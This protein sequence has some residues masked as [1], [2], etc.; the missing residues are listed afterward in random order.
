MLRE[1][2]EPDAEGKLREHDAEG[3]YRKFDAE[4]KLSIRY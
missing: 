4:R 1:N 2:I 3:K